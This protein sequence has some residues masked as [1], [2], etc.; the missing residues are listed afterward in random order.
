MKT[1]AMSISQSIQTQDCRHIVADENGRKRV[2]KAIAVLDR[3][4][5]NWKNGKGGCGI[6][7]QDETTPCR[8]TML[9]PFVLIV[10]CEGENK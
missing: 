10:K 6:L 4:G 9:Q 8:A 5:N 7:M 1:L 2:M 3:C